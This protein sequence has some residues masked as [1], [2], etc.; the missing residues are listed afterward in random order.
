MADDRY[1]V[2]SSDTHAGAEMRAYRGWLDP[3]YHEDFDEWAATVTNPWCDLRDPERAALNWDSDA[4]TAALDRIGVTGEVIFPNTLTPFYDILVH[5]GGVPRAAGE[6]ARRW[7]GLQA[8]NRWLADFCAHEPDR[9]RGIAQ[10]LPNDVDAAVAEVRW[11]AQTGV[12]GGVMIPS[13]PPNHVVAPFYDRRYDPLWDVCAATGL[14]VHQHMGSG[15][16]DIDDG[17]RVAWSILFAEH[18]LWPRRTLLHLVMGGVFERH[19]DLRVVWTEMWG[20]RWAV[21]ELDRIDH[22]LRIVQTRHAGDP[23]EL[24]YSA[25]FGSDAVDGLTLSPWEYW[26]RNCRIGASMLPRADVG[27]RHALG[28]ETVMWGDD[29]PHPEGAAEH[30]T[31]ALQATLHD[32]DR[33]ECEAM[34]TTNAAALY[35]FDLDA[36]AP[37]AARIGPRV[38]EVQTP[39]GAPPPVAGVPF[40]TEAAFEQRVAAAS[41]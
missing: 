14:A 25:T 34:L 2:L 21:E 31:E 17:Q 7:A 26:R 4:R 35:R 30:V 1:L 40:R 20:M 32:V 9:R 13:I 41:G 37:V 8:H 10:L 18:E 5:L 19:P 23:R 16:P 38:A 11:A 24:N 28:V 33:A 39:L 27:Y 15:S 29:F 12:I 6:Y 36:L 22:A 3:A